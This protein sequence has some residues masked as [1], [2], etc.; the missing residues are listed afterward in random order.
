MTTPK[1]IHG[2]LSA[3]AALSLAW[4]CVPVTPGHG[5]ASDGEVAVWRI[6]DGGRLPQAV[7][8]EGGTVHLVYF[9]GEAAEGDLN[10]RDPRAG[11]GIMVRAATCEQ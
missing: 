7:A 9:Q 11:R 4:G 5:V 3:A 8:D 10:V 2:V 1:A 6:P